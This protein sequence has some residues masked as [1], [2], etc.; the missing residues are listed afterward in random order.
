M[1]PEAAI[2]WDL[3]GAHLKAARLG[4]AGAV[5]EVVQLPCALWR[6]LSE[7]EQAL[8]HALEIVGTAPAQ[9]V[10]MTGEMV[11]LFP[12]RGE[13]V[14]RLVELARRRLGDGGLRFYA[15]GRGLVPASAAPAEGLRLASA[16]WLAVAEMVA[17]R[18][19]DGLLVDIGSTTTDIVPVRDGRVRARGADD[20]AR[21]V[22]GELAYTGVTRT[23]VMA[24]T[25]AV[26]F[27]GEMVPLMAEL[28][29]TTADVHRLCGRLPAEADLH[30][31]ADG[32]EKSETGSARRLARM[33]GLDADTAPLETWRALA[34][35]LA[36]AQLCRI[37]DACVRVL[38]REPLPPGAPVVAAGVGRFLT[39][40]LGARLGRPVLEFSRLL[41]DPGPRPGRVSDCAPAVAVAWL[42]QAQD[43]AGPRPD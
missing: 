10:T 8:D 3:G 5:E 26:P 28:F 7:L 22:S 9:A 15:A 6:G 2:G 37:E 29:A 25:P 36:E 17:D 4:P 31:A 32:G 35:R 1:R 34:G 42:S 24:L 30:P 43:G 20:A 21:L 19:G 41:P 40:E 18:L 39:T 12:G 38:S 13:G 16:N 23:P 33:V 14:A 11:D 27:A